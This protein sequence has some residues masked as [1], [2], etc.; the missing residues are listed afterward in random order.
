MKALGKMSGWDTESITIKSLRPGYGVLPYFENFDNWAITDIDKCYGASSTN[1][2]KPFAT[3][4]GS[5]FVKGLQG[6]KEFYSKE[7]LE[8]LKKSIEML[9]K[10][11]GKKHEIIEVENEQNME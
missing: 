5:A 10:G 8:H 1:S 2:G 4:S 3:W 6:D 9:E 11:E 7:N